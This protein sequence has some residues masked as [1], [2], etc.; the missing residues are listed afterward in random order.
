[1]CRSPTCNFSRQQIEHYSTHALTPW[2]RVLLEKL[3][4]FQLVKKFLTFYGTWR[5]ITTF[6]T[7]CHLSLSWASSI[8]SMPQHPTSWRPI[9]ILFPYSPI[10]A[11]VFEVVSFRQVS[12]PKLCI[13]ISSP[14]CV[15]HVPPISLFSI[16]SPEQYWVRKT[17]LSSSLRSF[18]HSL[19][20]LSLLSPN[21]LLYTLFSN[22]LSLRSFLSV[23]NHVSV[24]YKT[25][26]KI[27]VLSILIFKFLD[28]KLKRKYSAPIDSKHSNFNL[29]LIFL[30]NR[31]LVC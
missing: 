27:I 5:F 2:S 29:L 12:P 3:T 18:L 21:I 11:W 31:I 24:P 22:I 1:M 19:V 14:P 7:A 15:L 26:G 25:N 16:W 8:Q 9:L 17:S 6:T 10:Y 30:Q 4:G 28:S 20:T 23:G 13:H